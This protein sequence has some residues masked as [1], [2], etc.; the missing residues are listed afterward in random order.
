MHRETYEIPPI[1]S[2]TEKSTGQ[3]KMSGSRIYESKA[4]VLLNRIIES[5]NNLYVTEKFL[6]I[7]RIK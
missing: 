6:D 1:L 4:E 7:F 5:V 3:K 2:R